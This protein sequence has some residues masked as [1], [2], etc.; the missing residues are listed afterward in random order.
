[1]TPFPDRPRAPAASLPFS[2][3]KQNLDNNDIGDNIEPG[4]LSA[5]PS[6][7]ER[8]LATVLEKCRKLLRLEEA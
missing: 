5:A 6:Y 3:E 2:R 4:A 8:V 7:G 1:V